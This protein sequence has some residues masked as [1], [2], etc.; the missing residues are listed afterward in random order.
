MTRFKFKNNHNFNKRL[1]EAHRIMNKYKKKIPIIVEKS[2]NYSDLPDIDRSKYLVP[3]DLTMAEFMYVIRKRIQI[4]PDKSIF[5]FVENFG[6]APTSY[7]IK[8]IYE[9]AKDD[10]GFLYVKYCGESTFG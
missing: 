6:M 7:T 9:E 8:Q 10:D 3:N 1:E 5:M 4:T 2:D